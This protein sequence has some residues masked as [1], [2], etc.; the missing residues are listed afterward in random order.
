TLMGQ[1]LGFK[2]AIPGSIKDMLLKTIR[3]FADTQV[4]KKQDIYLQATK[5]TA[6]LRQQGYRAVDVLP[7]ERRIL[8][9]RAHYARA[10]NFLYKRDANMVTE[11][12][13]DFL[14]PHELG[15]VQLWMIL[16]YYLKFAAQVGVDVFLDMFMILTKGDFSKVFVDWG[17]NSLAD[18]EEFRYACDLIKTA[19]WLYGF[20]PNE[21]GLYIG[22]GQIEWNETVANIYAFKFIVNREKK[23]QEKEGLIANENAA[24]R[25]AVE[26]MA[27]GFNMALLLEP[28][29]VD[30]FKTIDSSI[31]YFHSYMS[32]WQ[33]ELFKKRVIELYDGS[34]G[35]QS[36]L[37]K[38]LIQ[39]QKTEQP[40]IMEKS[41]SPGFIVPTAASLRSEEGA[42]KAGRDHPKIIQSLVSGITMPATPSDKE[43]LVSYGKT[44]GKTNVDL[45]L[46]SFLALSPLRKDIG[47]NKL[48]ELINSAI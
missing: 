9:L 20:A 8:W 36:D 4:V 5:I 44:V 32:S 27:K 35:L 24:E 21:D 6:Q 16:S 22:P 12:F 11:H 43:R 41:L 47:E 46:K 39:R 14:L 45:Y 19:L 33:R 28:S 13:N 48:A 18:R 40:R 38:F 29:Q 37:Q 15:H 26:V 34:K 30:L 42:G 31:R 17:F 10:L 1:V 3:H 25:A 2:Q 23:R 7:Q